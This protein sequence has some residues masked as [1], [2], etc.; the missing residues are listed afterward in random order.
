MLAEGTKQFEHELSGEE[1]VAQMKAL[2]GMGDLVTN[3]NLPNCGQ[4]P[5]IPIGRIVETNAY[6]TGGQLTPVMAGPMKGV[7]HAMTLRV[8]DNFDQV[9]TCCLNRDLEGCLGA[10]QNDPLVTI[11]PADAETLFR[12]MIRNTSQ[13]LSYYN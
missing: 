13:W 5:N 12:C 1:G 9:V 11:S 10:F 4:I 3:V 8:S 6:F 2:M 7:P